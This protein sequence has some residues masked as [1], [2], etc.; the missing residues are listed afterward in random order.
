MAAN[1]EIKEILKK[2]NF[3]QKEANAFIKS[4]SVVKRSFNIEEENSMDAGKKDI[5]IE[6][7]FVG[8]IDEVFGNAI[9]KN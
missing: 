6:E 9:Q 7:E 8:I 4:L 3:N 5:N 1:N 2:L